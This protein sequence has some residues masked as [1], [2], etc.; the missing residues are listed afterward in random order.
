MSLGI[1][2]TIP[3]IMISNDE[4][5]KNL[6]KK[7]VIKKREKPNKYKYKSFSECKNRV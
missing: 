5:A 6:E 3:L 2:L 7:E 1:S 4:I